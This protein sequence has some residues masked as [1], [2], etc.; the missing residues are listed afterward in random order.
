VAY[1]LEIIYKLEVENLVD[2]SLKRLEFK[3]AGEIKVVD[4][5]WA[6]VLLIDKEYIKHK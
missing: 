3:G 1:N 5:L 6:Q 4:L 2:T